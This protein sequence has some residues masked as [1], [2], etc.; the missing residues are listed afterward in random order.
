MINYCPFE[1]LLAYPLR[2]G[3]T[4]A[5]SSRGSGIKMLN[6]GELFRH[7]Q[8]PALE[9]ARVEVSTVDSER[10]LLQPGDLMFARRSLTLEGA[11]KCSIVKEIDEP[12]TWE[13]SIIR[14]RL[15]KSLA[16]ALYYFYFFQSPVGR[17]AVEAIVEQVAAAGIRLSE[18]RK[19][20]VPVPSLVE[21]HAIAEVLG[22]LD[23]KIAANKTLVRTADELAG[24]ITRASV[25]LTE[26]VTLSE[27]ALIMM[28]SS[29]P[30]TSYNETGDGT[31]F[32]QGVRDFGA[33]YPH[34]RVWTTMPVRLAQRGDCL[35]SVRAPVG[36]LNLAGEATC[37]GRGLASVRSTENAPMSLFHLLKD[38]PYVWAPY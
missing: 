20:R 25:D 4:V 24:T 9:M 31:V 33:R 27:A 13:S 5:A 35:V 38:S 26:T 12:T 22:A 21:Q 17:R 29:P 19:L 3:V 15:D 6:M 18:L 37:I 23:D 32:Y 16:H 14:G 30:G 28:G 8:I 1:E 36:E 7:P 2:S 11:G 34:N 10:V